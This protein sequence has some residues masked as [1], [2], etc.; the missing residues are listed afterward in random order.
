MRKVLITG[1]AGFIGSNL[2]RYWLEKYPNDIVVGLDAMTYAAHPD[3]ALQ[4]VAEKGITPDRF[5]WCQCALENEHKLKFI[6][7]SVKPDL[8]IHLAAESHVCRSIE[9]PRKFLTSNVVGTYN[10]LEACHE[11]KVQRVHIVS[12]DEVYG[13]LPTNRPEEK[14]SETRAHAPRSPYAASKSAADQFAMAFYHT[15]AL[16]VTISNCSNNFGPNQDTEKLVPK[17]ITRILNDKPVEVYG[18]GSQIRDWLHVS[19]HC[20]AID[21]IIHKG[22]VGQ[23]YCV[24]GNNELTNMTVI[25]SI[26]REI[27]KLDPSKKITYSYPDTRPTDDKRYAVDTTKMNVELG[28]SP[29]ADFESALRDTIKWYKTHEIKQETLF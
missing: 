5:S 16:P 20:S 23:T 21:A 3:W 12:T 1:W 26:Y 29:V 17:T 9:T 18:N 25:N 2:T 4:Y 8:V 6:I 27:V 13:E 19:D 14:F 22:T 10:L 24:G 15:Y 28:W 11:Y 7:A